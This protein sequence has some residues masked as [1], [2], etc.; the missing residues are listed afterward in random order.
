MNKA[1]FFSRGAVFAA[2]DTAIEDV[3][4]L[5]HKY[6][7]SFQLFGV[8][9]VDINTNKKGEAKSFYLA[10]EQDKAMARI[11]ELAVAQPLL[12]GTYFCMGKDKK[13]LDVYFADNTGDIRYIQNSARIK[14]WKPEPGMLTMAAAHHNLD[15]SI[16]WFVGTNNVDKKCAKAMG[17]TYVNA[18]DFRKSGID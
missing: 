14:C 7:R 1:I 5:M 4:R 9:N 12:K 10:W 3:T 18:K 17:V 15:L 8:F 16:S 6:A 13:G 11:E 2:N